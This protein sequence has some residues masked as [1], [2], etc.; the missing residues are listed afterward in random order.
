MA[1]LERT[2]VLI[3]PDAVQRGLVGEVLARF[4]RKG[5]KIIGLK[6]MR[7]DEVILQEHY[8]HV[9]DR[10][11]FAEL[12]QFM[13]SSP[14][15]IVAIEGLDVVNTVRAIAGIKPTDLGSIRGDYSLSNQK[16]VIHSSDSLETAEREIA[17][18][19]S[20]EELFEYDKDEWKYIFADSDR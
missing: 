3:K 15:V 1:Q 9:L 10:P 8:A 12:S 19:F 2:L 7:L 5:L 6:M 16:N 14:V 11:F 13:S 20:E 4:E 18:F 17:R